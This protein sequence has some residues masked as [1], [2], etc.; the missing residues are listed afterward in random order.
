MF[1]PPRCDGLQKGDG[2]FTLNIA[3]S[4][5][6]LSFDRSS[7][8]PLADFNSHL[9]QRLTRCLAIQNR[10]ARHMSSQ[11]ATASQVLLDELFRAA[12]FISPDTSNHLKRRHGRNE[13]IVGVNTIW[14][15]VFTK[16]TAERYNGS[17]QLPPSENVVM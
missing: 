17:L 1:Q 12:C 5:G 6:S 3:S 10:Q 9:V 2:Y 11:T 4:A 13:H 16:K 14:E 7:V 15:L 8:I